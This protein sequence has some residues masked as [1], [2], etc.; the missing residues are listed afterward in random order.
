[1]RFL[2]KGAL[3]A[4]L[5]S[6]AALGWAAV[7]VGQAKKIA[8]HG[9][10][11]IDDVR[12]QLISFSGQITS[13]VKGC[14]KNR[15]DGQLLFRNDST[16]VVSRL[17]GIATDRHGNWARSNVHG[18]LGTFAADFPKRTVKHKTCKASQA[19]VHFP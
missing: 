14:I 16:G 15:D 18:G 6:V 7:S 10:I 13:D 1:M 3:C 4:A 2:R 17:G 8:V 11:Q 5:I 19:K 12:G 9:V